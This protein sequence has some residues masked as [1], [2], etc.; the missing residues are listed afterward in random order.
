MQIF[1]NDR[2][3]Y[4][5]VAGAVMLTENLSL[6][7]NVTFGILSELRKKEI[8]VTLFLQLRYGLLA[9]SRAT[10]R[11]IPISLFCWESSLSENPDEKRG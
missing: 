4:W 11:H 7:N 8:K 5:T 2:L 6:A 3:C 9:I 1:H 10:A